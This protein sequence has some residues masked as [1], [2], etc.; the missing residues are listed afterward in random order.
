[1]GWIFQAKMCENVSHNTSWG[2]HYVE[3]D[4]GAQFEQGESRNA[5]A[6]F[7]QLAEGNLEAV[8]YAQEAPLEGPR[9]AEIDS[10][11]EAIAIQE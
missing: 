6:H 2:V 1:M 3:E 9:S 5:S 10:H 4:D 7:Q 11:D 8:N